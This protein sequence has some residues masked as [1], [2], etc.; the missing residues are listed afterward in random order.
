LSFSFISFSIIFR[1]S[2]AKAKDLAINQL[3]D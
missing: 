3:I 2:N 1:T